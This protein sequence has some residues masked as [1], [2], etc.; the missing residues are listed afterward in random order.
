MTETEYPFPSV[1]VQGD[2]IFT[3]GH[4]KECGLVL[5][6]LERD[7]PPEARDLCGGEICQLVAH[8]KTGKNAWKN[9]DWK[10]VAKEKK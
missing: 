7:G 9:K 5:A 4:C 2:R 8:N 3:V 10:Q 1:G 6:H